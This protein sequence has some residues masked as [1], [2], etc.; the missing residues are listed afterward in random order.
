VS[1]HGKHQIV[2]WPQTFERSCP[3]Y[4]TSHRSSRS[5]FLFLSAKTESK[6]DAVVEPNTEDEV[7][8]RW[9]HT[10]THTVNRPT[11]WTRVVLL[12]LFLSASTRR[13]KT[14]R[15]TAATTPAGRPSTRAPTSRA[16]WRASRCPRARGNGWG[17]WRRV[18]GARPGR[19][20]SILAETQPLQ[21]HKYTK[22][23]LGRMRRLKY[24][25]LQSFIRCI[26]SYRLVLIPSRQF[27]I[28]LHIKYVTW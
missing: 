16:P 7:T 14:L 15:A 9:G 6:W 28:W 11:V 18:R 21:W 22:F 5:C 19:Y 27:F 24:S 10:H 26:R 3:S 13:T 1:F 12:L 2:W 20:G 17:S 25:F 23:N 4:R 8:V